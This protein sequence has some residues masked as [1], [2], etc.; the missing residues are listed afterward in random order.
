MLRLVKSNIRRNLS[1]Y[2]FYYLALVI[3][4]AVVYIFISIPTNKDLLMIISAFEQILQTFRSSAIIVGLFSVMFMNYCTNYFIRNRSKEIAL[5]SLFGLKKTRIALI[6]VVENLIIGILGI[7]TGIAF[8]VFFSKFTM[9]LLMKY[10]DLSAIIGV[11][12]S[13]ESIFWT[14][15]VYLILILLSSLF[16]FYQVYKSSLLGLFKKRNIGE[17]SNINSFKLGYIGVFLILLGYFI[18]IIGVKTIHWFIYAVP[19]T[20]FLCIIGTF[21]VYRNFISAGLWRLTKNKE[22]VYKKGS[23]IWLRRISHR[24]RS[25]YKIIALITLL[26]AVALTAIGITNGLNIQLVAFNEVENPYQVNYVTEEVEK[27]HSI[28][29]LIKESRDVII[30][31]DFFELKKID[32]GQYVISEDNF[33]NID[34]DGKSLV[35]YFLENGRMQMPEEALHIN[36]E[37]FNIV[38]SMDR[39]LLN[40]YPLG[41]VYVMDSEKYNNYQGNQVI[42]RG[43]KFSNPIT[44]L[45]KIIE[46]NERLDLKSYTEISVILDQLTILLVFKV[47]VFISVIIGIIFIFS[48]ASILYI[49]VINSMKE[50]QDSFIT[51]RQIGFK[52]NQIKSFIK[53]FTKTFYYCPLVIGTIHS[54]VA[55]IMLKFLLLNPHVSGMNYKNIFWPSFK[56]FIIFYSVYFIFYRLTLNKS[57]EKLI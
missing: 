46:I 54:V 44:N 1:T 36:G 20:L 30:S 32:E 8:G 31:N 7:V 47:I 33:E 50:D 38:S 28:Q 48:S 29:D 55:L 5:Y 40:R 37:V 42:S 24:L 34:V 39:S 45:E 22:L 41:K 4:I 18:G 26:I 11:T 2:L 27:D 25:S 21:L 57:Y 17:V 23:I 10:L 9:M 52:E 15:S 19:I 49:K 3:N 35:A 53:N 51:L 6:L 14:V 56:I 13:S 16:I 43:L 12:I